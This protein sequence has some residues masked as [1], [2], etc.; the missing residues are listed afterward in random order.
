MATQKLLLEAQVIMDSYYQDFAPD[1]S[2]FRIED[3]A[4]WVGKAYGKMADETAKEIYKN[5]LM[6]GGIGQLIFS[7]DWWAKK[8]YVLKD[9]SCEID[10]KSV[11]F[12]YDTQ[13][14]FIQEIIAPGNSLIRTT[15]TELW[16]LQG[17]S[18]SNTV[19]WYP[20]PGNCDEK[21]KVTFWSNSDC[22]PKKVDIYYIPAA[23]DDNFKIPSSKAFEIAAL[24]FN[25]MISAKKETP[26]V[27]MTNNTNPNVAPQT[28]IDTKQAP[29]VKQ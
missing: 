8:S 4:E 29:Q 28:E 18:K 19:Y 25:F 12:T 14:S 1:D 10:F 27:D 11:G 17:M 7:Q 24:A 15:I 20:L 6:E 9:N 2:F 13:N 21:G 26:V 5:S 16:I 23:D 22:I 3:F